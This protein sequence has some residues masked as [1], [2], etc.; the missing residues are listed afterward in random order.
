MD[1]HIMDY[2][3]ISNTGY[4][5]PCSRVTWFLAS[6]GLLRNT[7]RSALAAAAIHIKSWSKLI[8]YIAQVPPT[9]PGPKGAFIRRGRCAKERM[10]VIPSPP[11]ITKPQLAG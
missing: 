6:R 5:E 10:P 3:G 11:I 7:S 9:L 2:M 1:I 8:G 4:I